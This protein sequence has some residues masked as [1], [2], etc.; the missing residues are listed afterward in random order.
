M[1][2]TAT[3]AREAGNGVLNFYIHDLAASFR[4]EIEGSFSGK[5]VTQVEQSWLTAS[6]VIGN[7]ALVI[8][9]GNVANM[10]AAGRALLRRW[11][12]DGAQFVAKSPLGNQLIG[13][14]TGQPVTSGMEAAK[15]DGRAWLRASGLRLLPLL[16]LLFPVTAI[17]G[18]S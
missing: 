12:E 11:H 5:G 14:I 8:V 16:L 9:L 3:Y 4:I 7:R 15:D 2:R 18:N 17:A 13:S 1:N 6:S 10:D